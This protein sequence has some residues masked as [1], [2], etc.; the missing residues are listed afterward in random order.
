MSIR[1][2]FFELNRQIPAGISWPD[3]AE[4]VRREMEGQG[5][6]MSYFHR[7]I[8]GRE[9]QILLLEVRDGDRLLPAFAV[10]APQAEVVGLYW[11]QDMPALEMEP[12]AA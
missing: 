2:P 5:A 10:Y 11:K 4:W 9:A 7:F 1:V 6:L 12:W 3:F 8:D